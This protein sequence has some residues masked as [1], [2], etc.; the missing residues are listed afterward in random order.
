MN[1][2]NATA[3]M[4]DLFAQYHSMLHRYGLK[5]ILRDNWMITVDHVLLAIRPTSLDMQLEL[6]LSFSHHHLGKDFKGLPSHAIELTKA[7]QNVFHGPFSRCRAMTRI[8]PEV[9]MLTRIFST[10]RRIT[11]R[12]VVMQMPIN[13]SSKEHL[14]A[15]GNHTVRK[16]FVIC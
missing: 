9:P 16:A 15:S 12:K 6:D 11:R 13:D 10:S 14:Y 3:R 2:T 4:Q 7:F 5:W 1:N 8:T